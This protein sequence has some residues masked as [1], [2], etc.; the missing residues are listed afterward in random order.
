M[1]GYR[2][3]ILPS[4]QT[5][6]GRCCTN[7]H[8]WF[9]D[10]L[11]HDAKTLAPLG[12][13]STS[14]S[15]GFLHGTLIANWYLLTDSPYMVYGEVPL[16]NGGVQRMTE[17]RFRPPGATSDSIVNETPVTSPLAPSCGSFAPVFEIHPSQQSPG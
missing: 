7:V 13:L 2:R 8:L 12:Y 10:L 16:P 4:E 6:V 15:G 14:S 9:N 17:V 11:R 5:S 3:R 1:T